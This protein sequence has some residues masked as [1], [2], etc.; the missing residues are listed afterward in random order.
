MRLFARYGPEEGLRRIK[1]ETPEVAVFF[2]RFMEKNA[3][4]PEKEN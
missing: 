1:E 3:A 4:S 2:E